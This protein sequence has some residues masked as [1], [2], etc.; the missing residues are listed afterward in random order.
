MPLVHG[1]ELCPHIWTHASQAP[2][3]AQPSPQ[4]WAAWVSHLAAPAS[5]PRA[6]SG[7]E[8]RV[9]AAL[10]VS[11]LVYCN[12]LPFWNELPTVTHCWAFSEPESSTSSQLT[13][14]SAGFHEVWHAALP[15][16]TLPGHCSLLPLACPCGLHR[17]KHRT[18]SQE[19][20]PDGPKPSHHLS[21]MTTAL[22]APGQPLLSHSRREGLSHSHGAAWRGHDGAQSWCCWSHDKQ[23]CQ[24]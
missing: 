22:A 21:T 9:G 6:C 8:A 12:W 3:K 19:Q 11:A 15:D 16:L 13:E 20:P 7:S 18:S 23:E 2:H 24:A 1:T 10:P 5:A 17:P 14:S 4:T